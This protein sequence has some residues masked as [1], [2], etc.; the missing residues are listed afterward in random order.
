LSNEVL[1]LVERLRLAPLRRLTNR[2]RGEHLS[3]R[4]GASI[5][6]ADY[7]DYVAG[8][9]LRHIDWNIFSRLNHPYL[10]LYAHEEDLH[11][12]LILDA[13]SSMACEEKFGLA[14]QL[15]AA[16]GVMG[17][18]N[19]ERVSVYSCAG[20]GRAP[21]C[22]TPCRGRA[23]LRR[24]LQFLEGLSA[25]GD[26]PVEA[27]VEAALAKH[28]GRGIAIVLSD[29]LTFA[30]VAR[31]FNLLH[32]TGLEIY[33]LQILGPSERAPELTGDVRFVDMETQQTLDV[34]SIGE[35]LGLYHE[36]REALE[37]RLAD[38]CRRRNGRFLTISSSDPVES[39][40]F[41]Q[42]LRRGWIR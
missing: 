24:F 25:G 32:A 8:D 40:L 41:D 7:R 19:V 11:A 35:L 10:K 2:Q 18:M 14:R 12:V 36:H 37:R 38:E 4:G 9:D 31:S 22:L 6:F 27:A 3:D 28:R 26:L 34:S 16:L 17:L 39:V 42:L 13:S 30:D 21:E 20:R 33:G 29:F 5:D 1:S 15:A 23:S